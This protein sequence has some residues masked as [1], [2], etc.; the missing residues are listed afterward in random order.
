MTHL[1]VDVSHGLTMPKIQLI[2]N[3][4]EFGLF[5]SVAESR[6]R[7]VAATVAS[8]AATYAAG[9]WAADYIFE[10]S[11]S[12][13]INLLIITA[14]MMLLLVAS[15]F[16][17]LLLGDLFFPGPWREQVIMGRTPADGSI[18]VDDHSAEFMIM[19]VLVVI[20]NAFALNW[21]ADGFLDRYHDEGF[22]AV[23]LRAEEP[24]ER[25]GAL[26]NIADPMN[27]ELWELPALQRIVMDA[28]DDPNAEVRQRAYWT[29]GLMKAVDAED[30]LIAVL[31]SDA[32]PADKAAA[33]VALGKIGDAPT[34][35]KP[36]EALATEASSP[37]AKVGA[38]RGL[39]L[40]GRQESVA[41][42]IELTK[43][44]DQDVMIH[45]YWAL[46]K[47]GSKKARPYVK[48]V[49][50]SNPAG[51]KRC[52][53]YD[54]MKM[55][56]TKADVL[57]ARREFQRVDSGQKKGDDC[58]HVV[59]TDHDK[60]QYYIVYGDSYREKLVKIVA[61]ADAFN[62]REWFQRLVND[63]NEPFRIRQVATEVL[64]QIKESR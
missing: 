10:Q 41:P 33:A 61:N 44:D 54:T 18:S 43:S 8:L 55:V 31:D 53:V 11:T 20:A 57:W 4:S 34:S 64:R 13:M 60:E 46:R 26:E 12:V 45:A 39:G 25:L 62:H 2:T 38:L 58:E 23:R 29:A 24:A 15:Y 3:V 9:L 40:L 51:L 52:A 35:R 48:Q 27:Y 6:A 59:W 7:L 49:I 42:L 14:M 28:F 30:K 17:T 37:T 22:F 32:S 56:A 21:A 5:R 16:G 47:I 50:D 19:L 63:P 36:L 1:S